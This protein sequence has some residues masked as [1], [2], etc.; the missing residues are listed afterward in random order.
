[1]KDNIKARKMKKGLY[2]I[3]FPYN[4]FNSKSN[5]KLRFVYKLSNHFSKSSLDFPVFF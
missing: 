3:T 1:M 4:P 5:D 2:R